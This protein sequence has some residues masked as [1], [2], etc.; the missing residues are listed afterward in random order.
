MSESEKAFKSQKSYRGS[1]MQVFCTGY[2]MAADK[3]KAERDA[4]KIMLDIAWD[5]VQEAGY[6]D[7]AHD[8]R[9]FMEGKGDEY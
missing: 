2:E 3:Y 8:L 7:F 9:A 4:L 6:E 5:A 1:E